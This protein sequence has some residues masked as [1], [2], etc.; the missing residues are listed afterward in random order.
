MLLWITFPA[1]FR[2][3]ESTRERQALAVWVDSKIANSLYL[4]MYMY[5][6]CVGFL[7][8]QT[9]LVSWAM[10][11]LKLKF[12]MLMTTLRSL[13]GTMMSLSV[14]MQSPARSVA[15]YTLK[16]KSKKR[17]MGK[18]VRGSSINCFLN[19]WSVVQNL[20]QKT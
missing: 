13:P 15:N 17:S 8:L 3:M 16:V 2:T 5:L 18:K 12:S 10:S 19:S 9:A 11:L 4:H 7:F 1:S 14:R 6:N 20:R